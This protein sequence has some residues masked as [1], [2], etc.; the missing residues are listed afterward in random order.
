[1]DK[2]PP[3]PNP[4]YIPPHRRQYPINREN[5]TNDELDSTTPDGRS[6]KIE[7]NV[8]LHRS[9]LDHLSLS[10]KAGIQEEVISP[11]PRYVPPHRRTQATIIGSLQRVSSL[12]KD[13]KDDH[14]QTK[15]DSMVD[16]KCT[17]F[18]KVNMADV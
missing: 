17:Q 6:G 4:K 14:S 12:K 11:I 7:D 9:S 3:I 13:R 15:S 8:S 16:T 1:M 5:I 2:K 18:M 10:E